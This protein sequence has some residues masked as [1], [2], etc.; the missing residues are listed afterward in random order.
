M[1]AL[2]EHEYLG[3]VLEAAEGGRMDDAVAIAAKGAAAFAG[4]LG[5]QPAAALLA[6]R[7]HRARAS[8]QPQSPSS[9]PAF[10][11]G[12]WPIDLELRRT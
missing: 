2:V 7:T 1:V 10:T 9:C 5:V 11:I 6:D 8:L 12:F 3:L 4:R